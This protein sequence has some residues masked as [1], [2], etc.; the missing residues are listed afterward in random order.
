M[1]EL[2]EVID[3]SDAVGVRLR[4]VSPD[5]EQGFPGELD[6][7][8]RFV[9]RGNRLEITYEATTTAPRAPARAR[10]ANAWIG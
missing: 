3:G 6:V 8:A 5:G 4:H 2:V 7:T 1:W 10:T 9:V